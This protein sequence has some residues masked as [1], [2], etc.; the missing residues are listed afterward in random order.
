MRRVILFF[1]PLL[2]VLL[3]TATAFAGSEGRFWKDEIVDLG[4]AL[5]STM[6]QYAEGHP[7]LLQKLTDYSEGYLSYG[8]SAAEH[9]GTHVDAPKH[10][11]PSGR[12]IDRITL[13]ELTGRAAVINVVEESRRNPDYELTLDDLRAW[14][15][16][17]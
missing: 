1:W 6:P 12:S 11:W 3:F 9:L 14:E 4:H 13:S 8:F 17:Y 7:F 15:L 16:K 5:E 10:F 2:A